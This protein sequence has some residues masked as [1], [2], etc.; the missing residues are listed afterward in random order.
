MIFYNK[1]LIEN[2]ITDYKIQNCVISYR[3]FTPMC[4]SL[5]KFHYDNRDKLINLSLKNFSTNGAG[6]LW[7]P[8]FFHKTTNLIFN[9]DIF[10][11]CCHTQDDIWFYLIRILNNIPCYLGKKEWGIFKTCHPSQTLF[12]R[13]NKR[14]IL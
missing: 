5:D 2:L 9:D 6:T 3:G 12:Y 1:K 4:D 13:F 7:K 11:N 8:Q 14:R 10:L